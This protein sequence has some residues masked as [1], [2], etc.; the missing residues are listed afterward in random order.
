VR[1]DGDPSA[2]NSDLLGAQGELSSASMLPM[3]TKLKNRD[4]LESVQVLHFFSLSR[5]TA[6]V[7][8]LI[9][10]G[11]AAGVLQP[12]SRMSW[13]SRGKEISW[14]GRMGQ[15][16]TK[17]STDPLFNPNKIMFRV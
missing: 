8:T 16:P 7:T 17:A 2:P 3:V 6:A 5:M 14:P 10:R 1:T 4:M 11:D 13:F 15:R 9:A 12:S